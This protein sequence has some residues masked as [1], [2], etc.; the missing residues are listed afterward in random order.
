[1]DVVL[2][3]TVLS[4][5][6]QDSVYHILRFLKIKTLYRYIGVNLCDNVIYMNYRSRFSVLGGFQTCWFRIW[7]LFYGIRHVWGTLAQ[8]HFIWPINFYITDQLLY[9][10]WNLKIFWL[11]FIGDGKVR[12]ADVLG[13]VPKFG[14]RWELG[15]QKF[16]PLS[17][18]Y[19][20][21]LFVC[22]CAGRS[23]HRETKELMRCKKIF[24]TPIPI[25]RKIGFHRIKPRPSRILRRPH[26]PCIEKF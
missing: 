6:F 13:E 2:H 23:S 14:N 15:S 7:Y 3:F 9:D 25:V 1:M 19:D 24:G 18:L 17:H 20:H 22:G 12:D 5:L 16:F 8:L 10:Q 26:V 4:T 11:V 21:I